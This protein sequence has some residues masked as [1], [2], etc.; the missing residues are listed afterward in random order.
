MDDLIRGES[1]YILG[2]TPDNDIHNNYSIP[3]EREREENVGVYC[4]SIEPVAA[5]CRLI[6]EG[7]TSNAN[8]NGRTMELTRVETSNTYIVVP[9]MPRMVLVMEVSNV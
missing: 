3:V 6:V 4:G 9:P 7:K 1:V 8:T 5:A 2:D